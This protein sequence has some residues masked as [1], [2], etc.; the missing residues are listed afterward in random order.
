MTDP[1]VA[2]S[3]DIPGVPTL[4]TDQNPAP[5]LIAGDDPLTI[6]LTITT[7]SGYTDTQSLDV[8]FD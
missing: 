5:V 6:R 7:A 4:L 1:I 8:I 2:W 3:W